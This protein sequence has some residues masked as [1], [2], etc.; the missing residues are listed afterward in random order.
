MDSE[1]YKRL[2][3]KTEERLRRSRNIIQDGKGTRTALGR[4]IQASDRNHALTSAKG[5]DKHPEL[6]GDVRDGQLKQ[7]TD[8]LDLD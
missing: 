2:V 7:A 4:L 6:G 8:D 3:T 5:L 1:E